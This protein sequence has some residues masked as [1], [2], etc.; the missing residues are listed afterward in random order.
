MIDSQ[1]TVTETNNRV[2]E[3]IEFVP[4]VVMR[5]LMDFCVKCDRG[6]LV[7]RDPL[8]EIITCLES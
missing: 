4:V 7:L 3:Y 6:T 1:H 8:S 2:K 5:A